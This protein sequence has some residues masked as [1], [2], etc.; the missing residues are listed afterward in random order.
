MSFEQFVFY[1]FSAI[2]LFAGL[3]VVSSRNAVKSALFLVLAFV[4]SAALWLMLQAEFLALVLVLV[5]VGAVMTLFL[6]VVMMLNL[7]TDTKR[8]KVMRYLPLGVVVLAV[9][10]GLVF[11]VIGPQ[12]FNPQLDPVEHSANFSNVAELGRVLY[13]T[14]VY[15]FELA[16][17][18]L[19]VAIIASITLA[20]RGRR[21]RKAQHPEQQVAVKREHYIRMVEMPT[22][23]KQENTGGKQK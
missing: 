14:Y 19:L 1:G 9:F 12:H 16:A 18:L 23:S 2:L 15:P 6:F 7:T 17:A 10:V 22:E 3:M 20:F 11:V 8:R 5:Y 4:V 21:K 13:T